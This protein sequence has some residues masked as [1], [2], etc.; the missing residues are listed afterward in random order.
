MKLYGIC[1]PSHRV[2]RDQWFLPTLQDDYE[3][4]LESHEQECPTGVYLEEGWMKT[5]E[6]KLD[7]I[8]RG[9]RENWGDVF[10]HSDMDVQFFGAT[11]NLIQEQM[12]GKDIVFQRDD[13]CG[14]ICAGF[15][16]CR[17]SENT[18][19]FFQEVKNRMHTDDRDDQSI[20]NTLLTQEQHPDVA[21][22]LLSR[23]F[24]GAGQFTDTEWKPGDAL[25]MPS[26]IVM[27]HANWTTG[28]ENKVAQLQYVRSMM[29]KTKIT[30]RI[31]KDTLSEEEY[32]LVQSSFQDQE[33]TRLRQAELI[34]TQK[35]HI[36][37]TEQTLREREPRRERRYM[38]SGDIVLE[39][40]A[41]DSGRL[42]QYQS[43]LSQKQDTIQW[44][45]RLANQQSEK[46]EAL[47]NEIQ[48]LQNV[49]QSHKELITNHQDMMRERSRD[50]ENK[51][52]ALQ[53]Y[54]RRLEEAEVKLRDT[55]NDLQAL[56]ADRTRDAVA[57]ARMESELNRNRARLQEKE[58]VI[59]AQQDSIREKHVLLETT[60]RE[61]ESLAKRAKE[62][63]GEI[64]RLTAV[65]DSM[66]E[67]VERR[68]NEV[69]TLQKEIH[70]LEEKLRERDAVVVHKEQALRRER[71]T[72]QDVT[73][74][75]HRKGAAI[76][77]MKNA[78]SYKIGKALAGPPVILLR[79]V[80][81]WKKTMAHQGNIRRWRRMHQDSSG[82][83]P[84]KIAM[85][86]QFE[87]ELHRCGW[88][89]AINALR[90]LHTEDGILFDG[91]IE[92]NF[93]WRT[94]G[95]K[96]PYDV[97]WVGIIHNP[98]NIPHW[99]MRYQSPQAI[100][101]TED[102][103]QSMP[104]CRGLYCLSQYHRK[105]L[106]KHL[107]IP[108]EALVHPTEIPS[109]QFS[110][111]AFRQNP[112]KKIVQIGWWLRRMHSIYELPTQQYRKI[113]LH[114]NVPYVY[115]MFESERRE[116]HYRGS[117]DSADVVTYLPDAQ[118]DDLLS[119]NIAFLHLYDSSAN[120]AII[121]CIARNTPILVNPL[122]AVREY[123]GDDYPLYFDTLEEAARKAE[124]PDLIEQ[125][126]VYLKALPIKAQ[127]SQ[128]AFLRSFASSR[129]Y[130]NLPFTHPG[131]P[132]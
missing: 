59:V 93:A 13:P 91:F 28:I 121:E 4:V 105:W 31:L 57:L 79:T 98:P 54:H 62:S 92:E 49:V 104:Y 110:L 123:L 24:Y 38:E 95:R 107:D 9:I 52:R 113:F 67:K 70:R 87:A 130:Q 76:T 36:W 43:L 26:S 77:R 97:P 16:A 61:I 46:I 18:L 10:L 75:M 39:H 120:N 71:Q 82:V 41:D 131:S 101:E 132:A 27:H 102:W 96:A 30:N 109:V 7:V 114:L 81:S 106:Q 84:K 44:Q 21:W 34:R 99:F 42:A 117:Y 22:G 83:Y 33:H 8:L 118:Y 115:E 12:K 6:H 65:R 68:K 103:K 48:H 129:I 122:E 127:F 86:S 14:G 53:E 3:L 112:E 128:A 88:P 23:D 60:Q 17:G 63:A 40:Y 19:R 111:D 69:A 74:A 126:H 51:D 72:V 55:R 50:V 20:L 29:E 25:P 89:Y 37:K 116:I 90:S 100:F 11:L 66:K 45:R 15:F 124:D 125:A 5:M 80:R 78:W 108:V 85:G 94:K 56:R 1:T 58:G 119:K 35:E 64:E 73:A 32:A 47:R 2:F